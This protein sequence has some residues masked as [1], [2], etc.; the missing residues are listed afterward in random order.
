MKKKKRD[1]LIKEIQNGGE[2]LPKERKWQI[3]ERRF[4]DVSWRDKRRTSPHNHW[5]PLQSVVAVIFDGTEPWKRRRTSLNP[6]Y[7]V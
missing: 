5:I 1:T 6:S 4:W 7:L 2:G 3:I